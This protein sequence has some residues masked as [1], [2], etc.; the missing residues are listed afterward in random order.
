MPRL[1]ATRFSVGKA[2][3]ERRFTHTDTTSGP[4]WACRAKSAWVQPLSL[5]IRRMVAARCSLSLSGAVAGI[6]GL[7]PNQPNYDANDYHPFLVPMQ[8]FKV[9]NGVESG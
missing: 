8:H 6:G 2:A 4:I 1:D 3:I 5:Q 9:L 7:S